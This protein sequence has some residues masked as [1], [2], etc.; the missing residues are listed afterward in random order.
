M[1]DEI[2]T[3]ANEIYMEYYGHLDDKV[4]YEEKIEEILVWLEGDD[5]PDDPMKFKGTLIA[6]WGEY[7]TEDIENEAL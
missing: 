7:D 3:L 2:R 6:E 5:M 1:N 4:H